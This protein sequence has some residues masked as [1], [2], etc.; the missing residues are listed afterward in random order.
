MASSV[1][2]S[3]ADCTEK[4]KMFLTALESPECAE[5]T[6]RSNRWR[7]A[8]TEAGYDPKVS[9]SD[10]IAPISHLVKEVADNILQRAA[11]E[12]AWTVADAAGSGLIDAQTKDRIS[13]AKDILDRTVPKKAE[14][15]NKSVQPIAVLILP[16]KHEVKLVESNNEDISPIKEG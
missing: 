4:Q 3:R 6:P 16:T 1:I 14:D 15:N 13:A 8:A 2:K 7:W 12:A 9:I 5:V 10:I 11:V